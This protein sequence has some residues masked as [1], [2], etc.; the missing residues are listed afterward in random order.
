MT[1]RRTGHS[2]SRGPLRTLLTVDD[3]IVQAPSN[4]I[5]ALSHFSIVFRIPHV[6]RRIKLSLEPN[7]D[8]F[9]EGAGVSFLNDRG[10]VHRWEP[11]DRQQHRIFKGAAWTEEADGSW[12]HVGWARINVLAD[13]ASP[14]F[15]GAFSVM[16]DNHHV[17]LRSKFLDTM[18]KDDP[19]VGISENQPMVLWRDSDTIRNHVHGDLKKREAGLACSADKLSFNSD[20]NHPVYQ[21]ISKR[22]APTWGYTPLSSLFA[23][24]Q[25]DTPGMPTGGNSAGANLT[26]TIGQTAGCPSIRKVALLGVATDC[27]YTGNFSSVEETRSHVIQTINTASEVYEKTFN[28]TL[29]LQNLTVSNGS[30][31]GS[32]PSTTPWNIGCDDRTT[33][34]DRLNTFSKWRGQF[35]DTN[36][37]WMLLTRCNTG[38]EV[39]LSWLGELCVNKVSDGNNESTSGANVVAYTS[40]EWQVIAHEAG[41]MFGAVH[42]CDSQTCSDGTTAQAQQCCPL[43]SSSCDAGQQF[44]MNPS[45]GSNLNSFSGCSIGNICSAMK[46]NSVRSDCLSDN[47]AVRTITGQ[48]CGNG[49]VEEG[50]D[51]DCG[52]PDGCKGDSCCNP[53]TC[54]FANGAVC[55]DANEDCCHNCHFAANGT[56]CRASTG[57]CDPQEVCSGTSGTCPPDQVTPN[58]QSCSNGLQCAS[59]QCTSRDQQCK[60]LMGSLTSKND[61]YACDSTDCTLTCASPDFPA[62]NCYQMQQ[63]FL[64]GTPC[65]GGSCSNVCYLTREGSTLADDQ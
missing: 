4:R 12:S 8:I 22:E 53:T 50:E 30:C 63:N 47:K 14:V 27:T 65:G 58:G 36:A 44:L 3:P 6:P 7:H 46:T 39:G 28:I 35:Q 41:H 21:G 29:G 43:S 34:T 49:I 18:H 62:G 9:P 5:N 20:P 13:G 59:G 52:G 33:I 1:R 51:C 64:D 48:Q 61:T 26:S 19:L 25:I 10:E 56:V 37:Y 57:F 15:E 31:P 2:Q 23:K 11:I 38:A 24:R 17:Q 45:T 54:K 32:P 16:H 42:D 60:T 55:D 40:T